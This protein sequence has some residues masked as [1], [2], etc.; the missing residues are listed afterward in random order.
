MIRSSKRD[1]AVYSCTMDDGGLEIAV[2]VGVVMFGHDFVWGTSKPLPSHS[3]PSRPIAPVMIADRAVMLAAFLNSL[4]FVAP[5]VHIPVTHTPAQ[6]VPRTPAP[7]ACAADTAQS[8]WVQHF[9]DESN[10]HF[11]HNTVTGESRWDPLECVQWTEHTTDDGQV[12]FFNAL[13]GASV[14][15]LPPDC[16][17]PVADASAFSE[18]WLIPAARAAPTLG[19]RIQYGEVV[20]TVP[21]IAGEDEL[22]ELLAAGLAARERSG[23]AQHGRHRFPVS[24]PG[25]FGGEVVLRCEE[26]LLRVLD[27]IDDHLPSV[28]ERLFRSCDEWPL[29]QPI[30]AQGRTI[31][32]PPALHLAETCPTLRELYMAGELE[33]SE[34]E[35]AINVYSERGQFGAHKDHLALTVLVPLTS[36]DQDYAGGGTGFWAGG[37]AVSEDPESAPTTV[38]KPPLGEAQRRAGPSGPLRALP[39]YAPSLLTAYSARGCARDRHGARL[40]R[41]RHPRGHARRG[42]LA[43]GLCRLL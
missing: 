32:E 31:A 41:R 34:G 25:A 17:L 29:R 11:F 21:N 42:G 20:V 2:G 40:R 33:W 27:F 7:L 16:R 36:A 43:L 28:Y 30:P 18:E 13:A 9:D 39:T 38:L 8:L 12:F 10:R 15:E 24:D 14:W 35:P 1:A 26:L 37:R 3:P 19:E 23:A 4:A 5:T 6:L 22:R